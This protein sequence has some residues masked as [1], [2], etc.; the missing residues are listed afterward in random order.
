MSKLLKFL[1]ALVAV[2]IGFFANDLIGFFQTSPKVSLDSYCQLST[3]ACAQDG[4]II[5]MNQD[6]AQPLQPFTLSVKWSSHQNENLML[7]LQGHEMDMGTARFAIARTPSGEYQSDVLLPACTMDDMTW[8]GTL[9]D[10]SQSVDV[11]IRMAR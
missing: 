10:G 9:S 2:S 7:T 8:I 4:V 6:T 1:S 11:A 5:S 3:E